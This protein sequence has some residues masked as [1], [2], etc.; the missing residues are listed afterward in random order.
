M[1][2]QSRKPTLQI[3]SQNAADEIMRFLLLRLD[4]VVNG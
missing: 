4:V 2:L 3:V 1:P